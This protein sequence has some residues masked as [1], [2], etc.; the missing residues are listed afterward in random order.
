MCKK[1]SRFAQ[2]NT[3]NG[4]VHIT[5]VTG[6]WIKNNPK[7]LWIFH[8]IFSSFASKIS[9]RLSCHDTARKANVEEEKKLW[10][11]NQIVRKMKIFYRSNEIYVMK[12]CLLFSSVSV[13]Y[14]I[15]V[16]D[17]TTNIYKR[18]ERPWCQQQH[19]QH[20]GSERESVRSQWF[21]LLFRNENF[22][23]E[24]VSEWMSEE[25]KLYEKE[26]KRK[27]KETTARSEK[28]EKLSAI[29]K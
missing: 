17:W 24:S 6:D 22:V 5:T 16:F 18:T 4:L 29:F 13:A 12:M 2:K 7:F 11:R 9:S 27:R 8:S 14:W 19:Q 23:K 10:K 1:R 28:R 15:S 25:V 3:S 26:E 21:F 20:N